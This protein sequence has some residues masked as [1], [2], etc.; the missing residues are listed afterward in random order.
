M[1]QLRLC[2]VLSGLLAVCVIPVFNQNSE[3]ERGMGLVKATPEQLRGIPLAHIPFSG[4][5]LPESVDLSG[6]MPPPGNQGKQNSCTAWAIAYALK[7]YQERLEENIPIVQNGRLDTS[8]V[9]SPAYVFNQLNNGRNSGIGFPDALNLVSDQGVVSLSEMPYSPLDLLTKPG[10]TLRTRAKRYRIDYW[11]K[12][13]ILD[14]KELKAHL[15]GGFPVM[16]GAAVD[17]PFMDHPRGQIWNSI[18]SVIGFHAMV[19]VGYS[20]RINAFKIMNSWGQEW[21]DNGFCWADYSHFRAVVQ[22]GYV[23]KDSLNGPAPPPDARPDPTP[24][25]PVRPRRSSIALTNVEHN[26]TFPDKPNLGYFMKFSGSIDIPPGQGYKDQ[27][28]IHFYYNPGGGNLGQSVRSL[29]SRY[30]DNDGYVACGTAV[31]DIPAEGLRTTWTTWL[32]Y[33]AFDVP[34]GGFVNGVYQKATTYLIAIPTIFIDNFG[35][36]Q[37]QRHEFSISW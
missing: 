28:V 18:D 14:T 12:V 7:S 29:D 10:P 6:F 20:D 32:P 9:F 15:N 4:M 8:R 24:A 13:N 23:A 36:A 22:E 31:Y 2:L 37:G 27:I 3:G 30:T 25:P 21:G 11:R 17:K 33:E 35:L 26:T 16:I 1:K 34:R 19:V 5:E